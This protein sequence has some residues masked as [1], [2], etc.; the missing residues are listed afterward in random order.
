MR[1]LSVLASGVQIALVAFAVAAF[2][3]PIA[4]QFYFFCVA[5]LAV[6]L[7]NACVAELS[8]ASPS[9]PGRC[10]ADLARARAVP[11]FRRRGR[12]LDDSGRIR[13]LNVVPTLMCGGTENQFMS[14][15]RSL[16]PCRFDLE[17]ACLRRLGR[18]RRR[19]R[20]AR[21]SAARVRRRHI[22]QRHGARRTRH[23]SPGTSPRAAST[24]CMPTASTATCSRFRRPAWPER[25]SSSR[26]FATRAPYLTPMQKRVQ[27]W[28]LPLCRLRS[29]QRRR[30]QGLADRAK[31]TTRRRSS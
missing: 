12:R 13:L 31:D 14:L 16:D 25:P 19:A 8:A 2:F 4:Y 20:R 6:A 15:G 5:G 18:F 27:R 23:G 11:G 17:F 10:D 1:D 9:W 24:S 30:R 7:R 22:P 26:R 28:C 3:H 21:H 29:G